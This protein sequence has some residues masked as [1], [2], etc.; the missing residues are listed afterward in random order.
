M[1]CVHACV[2]RNFEYGRFF[3]PSGVIGKMYAVEDVMY[4]EASLVWVTLSALGCYS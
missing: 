3:L 2:R 4:W 1:G